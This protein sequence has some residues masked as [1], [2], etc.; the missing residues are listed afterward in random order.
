M[1]VVEQKQGVGPLVGSDVIGAT[2]GSG[3]GAFVG[4]VELNSEQR[5]SVR[6]G[7]NLTLATKRMNLHQVCW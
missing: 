5:L 1:S 4:Y 6:T 2:V 7:K 3:V